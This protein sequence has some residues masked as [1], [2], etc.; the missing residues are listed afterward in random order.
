MQ[1]FKI[2]GTPLSLPSDAYTA[3]LRNLNDRRC[4]DV[5]IRL[6]RNLDYDLINK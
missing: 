2:Q 4:T 3:N 1:Q 6:S 5:P